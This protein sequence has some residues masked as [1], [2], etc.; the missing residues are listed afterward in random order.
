M[1][2][3]WKEILKTNV[4]PEINSYKKTQAIEKLKIEII[5]TE[6][7]VKESYLQK[8]K[9]YFPFIN[10]TT[11]FIQF[12]LL[13][14]GMFVITSTTFERTRLIL[15]TVMPVLAFLQMMELEKSFK[16]NM[17]EIEMSCK[18]D[19]K[20]VV[21]IKLMIN[22]VINLCIMT[23]FAYI[24]GVQFEYGSYLL[25][26]YFLV[27]FMITNVINIKLTKLLKNKSNE[28]TNITVMLLIN[29]VLFVLN[30]NFPYVYETSSV[31]VWIALLV[32]TTYYF[33]KLIFEFYEKEEEYIWNLQ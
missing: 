20:E 30:M 7:I 2:K 18:I 3:N 4:V 12:A 26:I 27:P 16:Y 13:F 25:I 19:L 11:L 32:V 33:I 23:I 28:L 17:Y 9:R 1:N 22:T 10:K 31:F 21:S 8:V 24:A 6:I 29:I 14:M 15:S 5:N